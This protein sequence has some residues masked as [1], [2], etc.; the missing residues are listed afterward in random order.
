MKS[1]MS[2]PCS[3]HPSLWQNLQGAP[4]PLYYYRNQGLGEAMAGFE[5]T[6]CYCSAQRKKMG[7]HPHCCGK[8]MS[9][10]GLAVHLS[11]HPGSCQLFPE[12]RSSSLVALEG[13]GGLQDRLV[14]QGAFL[15]KQSL[16]WLLISACRQGL[17]PET[18]SVGFVLPASAHL[19][20]PCNGA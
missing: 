7:N 9:T 2:S 11:V 5:T 13:L 14:S 10:A 18:L 4:V 16:A 17:E 6:P 20:E 3:R 1:R 8:E 19:G 15:Y 12:S